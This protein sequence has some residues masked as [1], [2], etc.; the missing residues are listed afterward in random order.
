MG[1]GESGDRRE[2]G[3]RGH[4]HRWEELGAGVVRAVGQAEG[5]EAGSQLCAPLLPLPRRL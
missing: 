3:G 5:E 2:C 1:F 4:K